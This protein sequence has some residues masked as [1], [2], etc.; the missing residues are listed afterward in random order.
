MT[1]FALLLIVIL[2]ISIPFS[3]LFV[4]L[5]DGGDDEKENTLL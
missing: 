3:F 1:Y 4:I 2:A 5:L